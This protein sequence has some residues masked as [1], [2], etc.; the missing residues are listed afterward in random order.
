MR[1]SLKG[2][3]PDLHCHSTFSILDG[4]GSPEAVVTRAVELGWNAACLTEHGWMGSVPRFYKACRAAKI[5]P[6]IGCEMYV[7][8][9]E[10]FGVRDKEVRSSSHHLSVLAL[11][12]EGYENLVVWNNVSMQPENFYYRPRISIDAM[13]ESAPWPL[14]HNVVM[15]GCMGGE[16][17]QCLLNN[18]GMAEAAGAFYIE[19]MKVVFPNFYV[20][21]QNH[22][23][24]KLMDR[25]LTEYEK[26]VEDE[27]IVQPQLLGLAAATETPII[28]TND[29]HYQRAEQ[30]KPHMA[31]IA[32]KF[33]GWS[34]DDDRRHA[35]D[36]GYW[37]NYMRPM[38]KVADG[39][40]P[41]SALQSIHDIV[42]ESDIRL[43]PLDEFSYSIPISG[44]KDPIDK[45]RR[46]C[47]KRL[48][49]LSEKHG[50]LAGVRFEHELEAMGDFAHYL[51]MMSDLIIWA[52]KQG[53]LTNTRGSAANSIVCYCLSIHD[54]D[55]I[56]YKLLFER[57]VNPERKKLPDIDIDIEKDRYEDFMTKAKEYI[58]EREGEGQIV[59]MGN[60]GTLANRSTF[61]MIAESLGIDK[62]KQDEIAKLLPQMIDSGL[63]DE[64]EDAYAALKEAYPDI[65]ELASG[66]F[67]SIKN[68]GQHA[69]AWL[70]GTKDRPLAQW[71]P[72]YLI[73]SSGKLVTQYDL[74]SLDDFG[75]VKGD[76]LRL[77]TLSVI[78]RTLAM[79]GYDSLDI[80]QIPL[81]DPETFE[82]LRAGKTEGIFTLQGKTNRQGVMEM[83]VESVHDVIKSV[84]IYR[85][86]L[87]RP[88]YHRVYNSRRRGDTPVEYP[89]DKTREILEETYG[90]PVF[91][92][93]IL[94][95]TLQA[96]FT[97]SESQEILDAIKKAKGVGRGAKELFAKFKPRYL[98]KARKVYGKS[99]EDVW[100]LIVSFQGYGF[101]RGHATSYGTLA[102]RAAY[103]KCHHSQEFYAA[104]LDVY[105]EKGRY[106][107]AARSDG[108]RI[109]PPDVNRSGYGFTRGEGANDIR[110]GLGRIKHVGKSAVDSIIAGQPFADV[111]DLR[112]RTDTRSVTKRTVEVLHDAGALQPLGI[113]TD[114]SDT[115]ELQLLGF[116]IGKPAAFRKIGKPAFSGKRTNEK[117]SHVGL[118]SGV[119]P[120][121]YR[122]SAS[123]K[124]WV[125]PLD[126]NELLQLKASPWARVKT[127]LLLVVDENGL[128][129]HVMVN[130]D[131]EA[132][133][134]YLQ[135]IVRKHKGNVICFDGAI[136]S[137]F[138]QEGPLG[139]RMYDVTGAVKEQPQVWGAKDDKDVRAFVLLSRKKRKEN[140]HRRAA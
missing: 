90:L 77:K 100:E 14:H 58:E 97:V 2:N 115:R 113:R 31:M 27:R 57:F 131:R 107:A 66:V 9:H 139:F 127:W 111:D 74:N 106:I 96:G 128:P 43:D 70:L 79:S 23:I 73:A 35:L 39:R 89:H 8:P 15:S 129:F 6:I 37:T 140:K 110:V 62:E 94:E 126:D 99:A 48:R 104:L 116:V 20:E 112:A 38:E 44:Y 54:I 137:P 64:E 92:E 52:K 121:P 105:P 33:Q 59:Q 71:I 93:Q 123:K 133:S 60:Y 46:R 72:L 10:I 13:I 1:K 87:T 55:S 102:V 50:E 98:K 138:E 119:D 7:V 4:L 67:D 5:K 19:S 61:R 122:S 65:Y 25:G 26:I 34:K 130:E 80:S 29:S 36:Y 84:A 101:N 81:D 103:L 42:T 86:S 51:L 76:W 3:A 16:L 24:D 28:V 11:S 53:I 47:R 82:M 21:L 117:W 109:L 135:W 40:I 18:N 132:E 41:Q 68:I 83:E 120:T 32:S 136:R 108:F 56:E 125:P 63:V 12:R 91:Q 17:C 95:L 49:D 134:E 78:K 45:I 69:C 75:L 88:G 30:R 124:F 22:R 85:P 114:Q 118:V